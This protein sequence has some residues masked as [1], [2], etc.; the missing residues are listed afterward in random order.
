MAFNDLVGG[1]C[2]GANPLMKLTS[3]FTHDKSLRQEGL[4]PAIE[5]HQQEPAAMV[6]ANTFHMQHL[7][8]SIQSSNP[9]AAAVASAALTG[10]MQRSHGAAPIDMAAR[11]HEAHMHG[12]AGGGGAGAVVSTAPLHAAIHSAKPQLSTQR[13]N[14]AAGWAPPPYLAHPGLRQSL[15][16][17]PML[18]QQPQQTWSKE[19]AAQWEADFKAKEAAE[20]EITEDGE[21]E[22]QRTAKNLLSEM[23]ETPAADTGFADF[24]RSVG[25]G[26][27][28]FDEN[29]AAAATASRWTE[30]FLRTRNE[31]AEETD[32]RANPAYWENLQKEWEKLAQEQSN[33]FPWLEEHEQDFAQKEYE[34]HKDNEFLDHTNPLEE[35]LKKLQEGD[36]ASA[37]LYFEAEVK[38]RPDSIQGWQYLGTTLANNEQEPEAI[39][40]L[41]KCLSLESGNLTALMTLAVG[42]TN[43][44]YPLQACDTLCEWVKA[45]PAYSHLAA[46]S[47]DIPESAD[48]RASSLMSQ[49]K[50]QHAQQLFLD[51]ARISPDKLDADV[52]V[53]LGVLFHL[54]LEYD[55]AIDCFTAAVHAQPDNAHLWNKLGATLA[56]SNRS[57]EAVDAYRQALALS[58]GFIRC[59]YN[60]GISC[61]N[62]GAHKEAS[63]HFVSS[64]DQQRQGRALDGQRSTMSDSIWRTL[65]TCLVLLGGDRNLLRLADDFDLDGLI[66]EMGIQRI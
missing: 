29:G 25:N 30:E 42:L 32:T 22:L 50:F 7:L 38:A 12:A 31:E 55:K 24:V 5:L 20:T 57:A 9:A 66:K 62:L 46:T 10:D 19:A 65:R 17:M 59:R 54:A 4:A 35:G 16:S 33:D 14:V 43:E 6:A 28:S 48:A 27:L 47:A 26:E 21:T 39:I 11:W 53:G 36:L 1:E 60:L 37:I 40:A 8:N 52:Q 41:K 58:P 49:S 18:Q 23:E 56:N 45:N 34:F 61:M 3:H 13:G 2:G 44:N 64:L 63:E 51:A 15:A